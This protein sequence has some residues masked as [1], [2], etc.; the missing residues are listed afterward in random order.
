MS[1]PPPVR[2]TIPYVVS[3]V[4]GFGL[5]YAAVALFV[6]PARPAEAAAEITVPNVVGT[7]YKD[8]TAQLKTLGL[9]PAR[10][11]KRYDPGSP[12]GMVLR[13]NPTANA[14]VPKGTPVV[15]DVSLGEQ[16]ATVPAIVGVTQ[17][18]ARLA[19]QNASLILGT[20]SE[21]KNSAPRGQVLSST[22]PAGASV[23]VPSS[24]NLVVSAGP[25]SIGMPDVT[26]QRYADARTLLMQLGLVIGQASYDPT[27][28]LPQNTVVAQS[29]AANSPIAAGSRVTLTI[30][31]HAPQ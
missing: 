4:F 19:L 2:R 5:A 7:D 28:L 10:G 29:P 25:D 30:A 15:L 21:V 31:G 22:P 20:V 8:A 6:F 1:I 13:Q 16:Q 12:V 18:R 17:E 26:G 27:S 14:I 3:A 24:V 23:A 9:S 11:L